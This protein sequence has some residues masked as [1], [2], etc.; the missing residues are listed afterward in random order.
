MLYEMC[1]LYFFNNWFALFMQIRNFQRV[2]DVMYG[3]K[4]D[5]IWNCVSSLQMLYEMHILCFSNNWF[6]LF[7]QT[8]NFQ[9]VFD[10]MYGPKPDVIL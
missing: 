10:A 8:R 2:F 3:P 7:M 4:S 1:I 6:A 9:R 5:I